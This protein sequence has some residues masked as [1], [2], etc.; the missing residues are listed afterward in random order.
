MV[1]LVQQDHHAVTMINIWSRAN[2]RRLSSNG[3]AHALHP[4]MTW[5][6][7]ATPPPLLVAPPP[8]LTQG[9]NFCDGA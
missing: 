1:Q 5:T 8:F 6:M 4:D 9:E 2:R 3:Q 7:V